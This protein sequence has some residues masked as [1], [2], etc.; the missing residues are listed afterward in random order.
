MIGFMNKIQIDHLLQSEVV[1]RIGCSAEGKVYVVPITYVFDGKNIYG[2][3]S[4]GLK[5]DMMRV[6]PHVCFEV[7]HIENLA[8]WQSVVAWGMYEELQGKDAEAA[9]QQIVNRVHPFI[10]S[11][12][13]VPRHG[14]DNPQALVSPHIEVVVFKIKITETTGKFEKQ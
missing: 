12:T 4:V 1:G 14:L 8:N 13:S 6:N 9:L 3:T 11:E 2:H 7:D 10:S 5:V